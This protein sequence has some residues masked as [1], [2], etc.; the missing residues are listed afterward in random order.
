[1]RVFDEIDGGDAPTALAAPEATQMQE[2][3][4]TSPNTDSVAADNTK[5][6]TDTDDVT[7]D[8]SQRLKAARTIVT[9][10]TSAASTAH[11]VEVPALNTTTPMYAEA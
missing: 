3:D 6:H 8:L 10:K 4:I 1:M 7:C 11:D 5:A 9:T 2:I